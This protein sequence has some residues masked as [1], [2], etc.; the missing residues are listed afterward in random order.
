LRIST[1]LKHNLILCFD[2]SCLVLAGAQEDHGIGSAAAKV[3]AESMY[4]GKVKEMGLVLLQKDAYIP[5]QNDGGFGMLASYDRLTEAEV[6]KLQLKLARAI[7]VFMEI[8]HLLIARNRDL[9]LEVMEAR[10]R[11]EVI[12]TAAS[13]G[14]Q[15][16]GAASV[17]RSRSGTPESTSRQRGHSR[18]LSNA[19]GIS[20]GF[21]SIGETEASRDASASNFSSLMANDKTD[22]N[23]AV[24]SELQRTF[25]GMAK[26]LY[27]P[28]TAI[29]GEDTPRWLKE[30]CKDNYFSSSIYKRTE[31]EIRMAEEIYFFTPNNLISG[32][33]DQGENYAPPFQVM[34]ID[35]SAHSL[36]YDSTNGSMGGR[37]RGS[38]PRRRGV[39]K[40][41]TFGSG[42]S[43]D[44]SVFHV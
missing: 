5:E 35:S 24:Q 11:G 9:L 7:V 10:K 8:L 18:G 3:V 28:L 38:T 4:S 40:Q 32:A 41:N 25:I 26:T 22:K 2:F 16:R 27:N 37:S 39:S 44:S 34:S 14:Y 20:T 42:L 43:T 21:V 36:G 30:I 1:Q 29:L 31:N 13:V 17:A 23:I 33:P 12:S 6:I 19:S 15:N